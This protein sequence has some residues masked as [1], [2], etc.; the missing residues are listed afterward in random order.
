[1][2]V[3]TTSAPG[4]VSGRARD[5][6]DEHNLP[7]RIVKLS[8]SGEVTA[9]RCQ[10]A[11]E[12]ALKKQG[13]EIAEEVAH[14]LHGGLE[15]EVTQGV[16]EIDAWVEFALLDGIADMWYRSPSLRWRGGTG[17]CRVRESCHRGP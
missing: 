1:M 11:L 10:H 12:T 3:R 15:V 9:M 14:V 16:G 7:H 4:A 13:I 17:G 6:A 5:V 8:P 2:L